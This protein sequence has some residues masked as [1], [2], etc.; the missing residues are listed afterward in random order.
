MRNYSEPRKKSVKKLVSVS[1]TS[2]P[3]T[4]TTRNPTLE[5]VLSIRYLVRLRQKNNE[6]ENKDV[7]ALIDLGSKVNVMHP[8]YAI[9]LGLHARKIDVSIQK[10]DGYYLDTFKIVIADCLVK[11][12]LESVQ[13]FQ[14]I[15]LLANIGLEIVLGMYFPTLSK[16]NIRFMERELVWRTYTAAEI[17]LTNR[18][19]EII[20]KKEFA[21]AGMNVDDEI[22][23][24]HIGPL[25][26]PTTMPIDPPV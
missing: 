18:R 3:I 11:D 4:D 8:I 17:L 2:A 9:K 20:E 14:K 19:V 13:F 24:V 7:R 5:R 10:I 26:E 1:V 22:F 15:F 16:T 23:V 12:K 21:A 6:N 25:A